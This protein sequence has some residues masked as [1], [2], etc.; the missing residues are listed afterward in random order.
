MLGETHDE[1]QLNL[2]ITLASCLNAKNLLANKQG[3]L[4]FQLVFGQRPKLLSTSCD[5]PGVYIPANVR[6][7]QRI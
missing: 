6:Y 3:F 7:S 5:K 2:E 4:L 1:Q